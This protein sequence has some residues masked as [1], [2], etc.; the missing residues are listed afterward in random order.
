VNSKLPNKL[1]KKIEP[2]KTINLKKEQKQTVI[3]V[4]T[5]IPGWK[6]TAEYCVMSMEVSSSKKKKKINHLSH[7]SHG[8]A[9]TVGRSMDP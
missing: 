1:P 3:K 4:K 6:L 5:P 8:H 2:R 9:R 7:K